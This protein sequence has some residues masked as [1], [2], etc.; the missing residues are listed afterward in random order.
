[1]ISNF[2]G[3][4]ISRHTS[5]ELLLFEDNP[6]KTIDYTLGGDITVCICSTVKAVHGH[7][8][9]VR[10]KVSNADCGIIFV[11]HGVFKFPNAL[12]HGTIPSHQ[13]PENRGKENTGK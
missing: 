6:M 12:K 2:Y 4:Y 13:V 5:E 7:Y 1:M 3:F 8:L 11:W 9:P 10:A